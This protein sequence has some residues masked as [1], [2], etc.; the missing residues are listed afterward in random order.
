MQENWKTVI[1][2]HRRENLKKCSLQPLIHHP[3]LLFINYPFSS[4]PLMKETSIVLSLD[5]PVLSEKDAGNDLILM[6][7][8]WHLAAKMEKNL[9]PSIQQFQ[10]RTLPST[11]RT[12][13]PRKQTGCLDPLRG[14]ASVEALF[15]AFQLLGKNTDG[16]L[17]H[18]Y[19][20]EEFL[21]VNRFLR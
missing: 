3:D 21:A 19:W 6:D 8:T 1:I 5:G 16:L 18:Y 2:R 15:I 12:A 11:I 20:R 14:L 7:A 9:A 4:P 13:Y 17:D 10:K